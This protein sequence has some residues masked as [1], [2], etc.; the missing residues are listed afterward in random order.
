[1]C[2]AGT[3]LAATGQVSNACLTCD[4]GKHAANPGASAC[5]DCVAGK[6]RQTSTS[7][8]NCVAG[9]FSATPATLVCSNCQAG[10]FTSGCPCNLRAKASRVSL[11]GCSH[12]DMCV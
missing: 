2:A 5:L 6:F 1:L 10:S 9:K 4:D 11:P 7:C 12:V 8:S 3:Y